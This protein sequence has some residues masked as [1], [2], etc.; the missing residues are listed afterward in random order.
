M[1]YQEK[2][3]A[4]AA[5]YEAYIN[6]P[7]PV[8]YL[9]D[10]DPHSNPAEAVNEWAN[11]RALTYEG[12]PIDGKKTKVFAYIGF[13]E[14][15]SAEKKVPAIVLVHGGGGHAFAEWVKIW[16]DRG[17]AAIA[18]DNT[19]FFPSEEGRGIAGMEALDGNDT[20]REPAAKNGHAALWHHGLYGVLA[21]DDYTGIPTN[22]AMGKGDGPLEQ[23]W[24]YHAVASTF[25]AHNILLADA[26]VDTTRVGITGVSWGG[27]ITSLAIGYD[28]RY[29]FAIPIYGSG[30][31]HE[32]H[33][34]MKPIFSYD[35][36]LA[37]WAAQERFDNVKMPVLWLCWCNDTA[38]SINS[39]SASYMDTKAA[40]AQ[41]SM[42][43]NFGH[44]HVRGWAPLESYVF[45]DAVVKGGPALTRVVTE[46]KGREWS[47]TIEP[48]VSAT[49]ITARIVYITEP[50]SYSVKEEGRQAS[51]D[52]VWK[53]VPC[54]IDGTTVTG[55][56]PEEAH[57]YFVELTT[58]TSAGEYIITTQFFE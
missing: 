46:P 10:Y 33:T 31:L 42:R 21:Q 39:N 54:T 3:D 35:A 8:Q 38:F 32:A 50:L 51:I 9:P 53:S 5:A 12:L 23:Q 29:A 28:T 24:M 1:N 40:G 36:S 44:S 25:G 16:T 20:A 34:W 14:G 55:V 17:Y 13:P 27:V 22:D 57:S 4:I 26:R 56:L 48:D 30:Y 45:A 7:T 15:A 6:A 19:G 43:V 47:F 58:K 49:E 41:L 2:K 37:L 18:M 11:I 52:Q